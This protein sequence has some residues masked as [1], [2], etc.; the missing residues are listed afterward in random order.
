[1]ATDLWYATPVLALCL[2][3]SPQGRLATV[4]DIH[5]FVIPQSASSWNLLTYYLNSPVYAVSS[6]FRT[7]LDRRPA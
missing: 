1:M 4:L 5:D 3:I 7:D 2:P 6:P